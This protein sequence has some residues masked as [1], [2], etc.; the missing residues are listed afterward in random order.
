M[1]RHCPITALC[2]HHSVTLCLESPASTPLPWKAAHAVP[3][4]TKGAVKPSPFT[5]ELMKR[6]LDIP[7]AEQM[8]E[9]HW[10]PPRAPSAGVG[11]CECVPMCKWVYILPQGSEA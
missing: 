4:L 11:G 7:L 3:H 8:P 5:L 1:Q 6:V 10:Q 2:P 9:P